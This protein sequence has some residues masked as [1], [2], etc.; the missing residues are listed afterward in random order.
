M[1]APPYLHQWELKKIHTKVVI[2]GS[3]QQPNKIMMSLPEEGGL[4]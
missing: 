3:A 1:G 4:K 2:V